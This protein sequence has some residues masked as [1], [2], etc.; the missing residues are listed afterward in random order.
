MD[1]GD[2]TGS[3]GEVIVMDDTVCVRRILLYLLEDGYGGGREGK[4]RE[5]KGGI[6]LRDREIF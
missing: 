4:G 3:E 6:V 5:G 1:G 2:G